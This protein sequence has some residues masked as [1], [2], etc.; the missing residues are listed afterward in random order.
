MNPEDPHNEQGR[1]DGR[2]GDNVV[3]FPRDWIG[4]REEL[5]PV[6]VPEGPDDFPPRAE[7]F[8]GEGSAAVQDALQGPRV[9]APGGAPV[10]EIRK[11]G[12]WHRVM[13]MPTGLTGR[14]PAG[15]PLRMPAGLARPLTGAVALAVAAGLLA[16]HL[17][18]T[19]GP[20]H[21]ARATH[22]GKRA[23]TSAAG[24]I[25]GALATVPRTRGAN[26]GPS[27]HKRGR[28]VRAHAVLRRAR[29]TTPAE[30]G[31]AHRTGA[32]DR[33][34]QPATERTNR[35]AASS[36]GNGGISPTESPTPTSG[37]RTSP[38]P[39]GGRGGGGSTSGPVGPGAPFGP[40][41]PG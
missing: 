38:G 20:G 26:R 9:A 41:R 15:L 23:S 39:S 34:I 40:G 2:R 14:L 28:S 11:H 7:D 29:G 35:P 18:G 19:T 3:R 1:T 33:S 30:T 22:S 10:A 13:R 32:S 12:R 25:P 5:V 27:P 24:R 21:S 4:P 8:W 6:G 16:I 31:T 17:L 36:R 37:G